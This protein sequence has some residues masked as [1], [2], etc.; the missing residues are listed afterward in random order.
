MSSEWFH[1]GLR[2]ACTRCGNC[3]TGAPG[4]VRVNAAEVAALA[5]LLALDLAGFLARYTRRLDDGTTSLVERE[6]HD[7]VFWDRELGCTVYSRRPTQC[8]AW[9]FWRRN[10]AS[11]EHWSAAA[12]G[13]P[14]IGQGELHSAAEV[15]HVAAQDGTSGEVPDASELA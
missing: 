3:C 6:N 13:C 4:A 8:R 15:A 7:C 12:R 1:D 14:G 9:P 2:F 10:V 5:E 11:P